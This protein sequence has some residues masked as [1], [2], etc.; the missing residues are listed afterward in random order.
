ME[1]VEERLNRNC[2]SALTKYSVLYHKNLSSKPEQPNGLIE[3]G[4]TK[5]KTQAPLKVVPKRFPIY[6]PIKRENDV[7][8]N[9]TVQYAYTPITMVLI[10]QKKGENKSSIVEN[11]IT[12]VGAVVKQEKLQNERVKIEENGFKW[13]GVNEVMEAYH[14]FARGKF[15]S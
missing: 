2:Q 6:Q 4:S 9:G 3:K 5:V 10:E 13:P 12:D 11:R 8:P 15:S 14:K 1:V 7:Y